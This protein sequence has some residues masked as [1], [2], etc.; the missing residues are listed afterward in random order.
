MIPGTTTD[1]GATPLN[2]ATTQ[3]TG[4]E[5]FV[6]GVS[7]GGVGIAAMRY[8][9][10][11]TKT[12]HFQKT[13]YFLEEDVQHVMIGNISSTSNASVISVLDQKCYAGTV[14]V[15]GLPQSAQTGL[16]R[17]VGAAFLWHGDVGYTF[18]RDTALSV[19]FGPKT[20]NWT[21]IGTSTQ[22]PTTVDLFAAWIT[23]ESLNAS[24]SYT[25]FPGLDFKTFLRKKSSLAIRDVQ[26]DGS[27]SAISDPAHETVMAVFWDAA[28]GA[29]EFP[30]SDLIPHFSIS[31]NGN[32]A[33]IYNLR[34]GDIT[35]SDPSQTLAAVVITLKLGSARGLPHWGD[36]LDRPKSRVFALPVGGAAGSSVTKNIR[37]F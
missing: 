11:A 21:A 34:T 6:G 26:N 17:S 13:W 7:D 16:H 2:C 1:Y 23:H 18:P 32:V 35:V 27:I 30:R 12:F 37:H 8:T 24:L 20:G 9:N 36:S 29:V 5:N 22:P 28:G 14:A 4:I 25:A 3:F 15:D 10:P 19:Q 31:A 33:V